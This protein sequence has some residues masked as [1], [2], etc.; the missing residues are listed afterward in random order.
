MAGDFADFL[1]PKTLSARARLRSLHADTNASYAIRGARSCIAL[2]T[3]SANS[4]L[5]GRSIRGDMAAMAAFP[6]TNLEPE[7]ALS[8]HNPRQIDQPKCLMVVRLMTSS[9]PI[10]PILTPSGVGLSE[11]IIL[12]SEPPPPSQRLHGVIMLLRWIPGWVIKNTHVEPTHRYVFWRVQDLSV[13]P[14]PSS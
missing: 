9:F 1:A 2:C 8:R 7:P 10:I 3:E 11:A 12:E 4:D 5:F 13:H 6:D 14:A